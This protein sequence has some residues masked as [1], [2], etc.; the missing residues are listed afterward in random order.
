[1]EPKLLL[2]NICEAVSI[3]TISS[4][5]SLI[6]NVVGWLWPWN[7]I[8]ITLI[9]L[10]WVVLEIYTRHGNFHYNSKNGFSPTF[11]RFVGAGT[12][13]AGQ[14]ILL[15]IMSF[16]FGQGVYCLPW[17]YP[18]HLVVF[19]STGF[20]L[21]LSGFWPYLKESGRKRF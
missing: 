17:P 21:H 2:K 10:C 20:L 11:N 3:S 6:W 7:W 12:Y 13:F 1:M 4:I 14:T 18:L 16:F 8:W 19:L 15:L 5:H 9:I